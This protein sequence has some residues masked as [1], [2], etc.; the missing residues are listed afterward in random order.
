MPIQFSFNLI[1]YLSLFGFFT[2]LPILS[3]K[4]NKQDI[5]DVYIL[6]FA[7]FSYPIIF[8]FMGSLCSYDDFTQ[9]FFLTLTLICFIDNKKIFSMLFFV[10]SCITRET[11]FVFLPF[12]LVHDVYIN[13]A[14][15]L[16]LCYW[17]I[18]IF[19]YSLFLFFYLEKNTLEHEKGFLLQQRFYAWQ[20]NFRDFN[21]VRE[22]TTLLLMMTFL[23]VK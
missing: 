13:R 17:L 20:S 11:S 18:P 2:L 5:E 7:L 10:V 14:S 15:V 6:G 16:K 9:F 19:V 1:N 23:L 12:F 22:T 4:I 21:A 8:A 3:K